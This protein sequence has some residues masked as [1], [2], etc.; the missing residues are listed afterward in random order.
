AC[1]K[2]AIIDVRQRSMKYIYDEAD[3]YVTLAD[4]PE[5]PV[6]S[7][8]VN[9]DYSSMKN[10]EEEILFELLGKYEEVFPSKPGL[11]KKEISRMLE[12]EIINRSD[13]PF[14]YPIVIV[15][16]FEGA[17][18][19]ALDARRSNQIIEEDRNAPPNLE[20]LLERSEEP[21]KKLG[22]MHKA[23]INFFYRRL[24]Q[25]H[26]L[27]WPDIVTCHYKTDVTAIVK[28]KE[29]EV[30]SNFGVFAKKNIRGLK[31]HQRISKDFA[32]YKQESAEKLPPNRNKQ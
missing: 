14:S 8:T 12:F 16:K 15:S 5:R 1:D 20:E 26:A 28:G 24:L 29:I 13:S 6:A 18:Q 4:C 2:Q 3:F 32:E 17:V 19:I 22:T 10:K 7:T 25:K 23:T 11:T 21:R 30:P 9:I 31:T 27:F